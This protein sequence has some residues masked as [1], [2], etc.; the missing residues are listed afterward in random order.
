MS[1]RSPEQPSNRFR[2]SGSKQSALL[3][4]AAT[5]L[6]ACDDSTPP[7]GDASIDR[8]VVD[9]Q[10][11]HDVPTED[12][13]D[14]VD[15]EDART[16]DA[17]GSD[18]GTT[19]TLYQFDVDYDGV[20][21]TNLSIVNCA[22]HTCMRVDSRTVPSGDIQIAPIPERCRS[23][24]VVGDRI[25]LLHRFFGETAGRVAVAHCEDN[26]THSPITLSILD[27]SAQRILTRAR[28]PSDKDSAWVTVAHGPNGVVVPALVPSYGD[29][30]TSGFYGSTIWGQACLYRPSL[31]STGNCGTG[32]IAADTTLPEANWFREVGGTVIDL[33][34]DGWED[35][36][37]SYHYWAKTISGQTGA[38]LGATRY[39]VAPNMNPV[40]FH[41][42][43]NYGTHSA[44]RGADNTV[45]T[46]IVAGAPVGTFDDYNCNVS[47]FLA[48]TTAPIGNV[49]AR[50]LAWA[51]YMGFA[52]TLF[53]RYA[54]VF[55][56]MPEQDIARPADVM[57]NC[58]HRFS[59]SY[60]VID[61]EPSLV[62]NYFR[63]TAPVDLCLAQQYQLYLA[64]TWTQA[65][66]DAWYGCFA[67]NVGARG[68]WATMALRVRDGNSVTGSV[69]T[70]V[71][72]RTSNLLSS[73]E[74]L[75]VVEA[76]LT[77]GRWDMADRMP[78]TMQVLALVRGLWVSRGVF[79]VAG[80]PRI[81][82]E[83]MRGARG[84]GS[85]TYYAELDEQDVD[86][87]GLSDIALSDGMRVGWSA[88][89]Q[90]FVLKGAGGR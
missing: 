69:G 12:R 88:A 86:G 89:M 24:A 55:A 64:P 15:V 6:I 18:G 81:L 7:H 22:G 58:V 67:R 37:L 42:G 25:T 60:S 35:L 74:T 9:R 63:Q 62:V 70:Y 28:T 65:K 78:G 85:F 87:D 21:D 54:D 1:K 16:P 66:Q 44:V 59:D 33:D 2:S 26:G 19:P 41:S 10:L 36:T 17:H 31:P 53:Q 50:Q 3:R 23:S 32:F 27:L 4:S 47:R 72:G 75:Y 90:R 5:I 73:H 76:G 83:P 56:A 77:E 52:S 14:R 20:K 43:R 61:G 79:P 46:L 40:G 57:N 48:V 39:D 38:V 82:R 11:P 45:R 49:G 34:G 30:D 71:W 8:V 84:V 80:R 68:T 51:R 29:G 13:T